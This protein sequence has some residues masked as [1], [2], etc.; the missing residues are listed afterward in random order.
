MHQ[1]LGQ[2]GCTLTQFNHNG[3]DAW[4]TANGHPFNLPAQAPDH[5]GYYA[6]VDFN[7][8][9]T[10]VD[11]LR[12]LPPFSLDQFLVDCETPPKPNGVTVRRHLPN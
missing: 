4:K 7:E 8:L 5:P 3:I 12:A 6:Q 1:W 11:Q 2:R 10:K 9:K